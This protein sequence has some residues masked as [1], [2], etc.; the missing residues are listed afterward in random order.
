MKTQ[1]ILNENIFDNIGVTKYEYGF[2]ERENSSIFF[3]F[4][5]L[6]KLFVHMCNG[7]PAKQGVSE[8][9]KR[10]DWCDIRYIPFLPLGERHFEIGVHYSK[11][12]DRKYKKGVSNIHP[13][14][15]AQIS[16]RPAETQRNR[17]I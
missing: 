14:F 2:C 11:D 3:T 17:L 6:V 8:V 4:K 16:L 13:I 5:F 9:S 12:T 7:F 15:T 1:E 10:E